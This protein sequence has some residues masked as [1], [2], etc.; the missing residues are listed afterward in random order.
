M[1]K[2]FQKENDE[3]KNEKTE[4]EEKKQNTTH[5]LHISLHSRL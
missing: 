2:V 3:K 4:E 1:C 5:V